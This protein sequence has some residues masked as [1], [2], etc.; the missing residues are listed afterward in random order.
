MY[1][2]RILIT[3]C[4]GYIGSVLTKKLKKKHQELISKFQ[5]SKILNL[6]KIN[7]LDKKKLN[8][9]INLL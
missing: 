4:S 6:K 5:K 7:L 9:F 3:G 8:K 1:K 2:K